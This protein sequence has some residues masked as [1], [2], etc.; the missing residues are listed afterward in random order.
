M[1]WVPGEE[2]A[3]MA[4][5][6]HTVIFINVFNEIAHLPACMTN[7]LQMRAVQREHL[8]YM[9]VH[10]MPNPLQHDTHL[11]NTKKYSNLLTLNMLC[12][13]YKDHPVKA[14]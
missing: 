7:I 5:V 6:Y 14:I 12:P 4:T 1:L 8:L 10:S 13:Y 11:H 3:H 2:Q 9:Q